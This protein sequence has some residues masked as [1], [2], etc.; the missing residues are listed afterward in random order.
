MFCRWDVQT[1]SMPLCLY[2]SLPLYRQ[3]GKQMIILWTH[4]SAW[5][6]Y[7]NQPSWVSNLG[8]AKLC[9]QYNVAFV[10]V[11]LCFYDVCA[12]EESQKR[13]QKKEREEGG[14][15][16]CLHTFA[17][18]SLGI[19]YQSEIRQACGRVS[20]LGTQWTTHK[21]FISSYLHPTPFPRHSSFSLS[22][23]SRFVYVQLISRSHMGR[24][25]CCLVNYIVGGLGQ[26]KEL[27]MSPV[28]NGFV[29]QSPTVGSISH[30]FIVVMAAYQTLK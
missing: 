17:H 8:S 13:E 5:S 28:N 18:L 7:H 4:Y 10:S 9:S 14:E 23:R 27:R 6:S 12:R 16:D 22:S 29:Q 24:S 20:I 3:T 2:F 30:C 19:F 26:L 11:L 25:T 1:P 21:G 15:M